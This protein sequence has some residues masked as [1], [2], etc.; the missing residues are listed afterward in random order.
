MTFIKSILQFVLTLLSLIIGY[1]YF[2][3]QL[4]L[5]LIFSALVFMMFSYINYQLK[6]KFPWLYLLLSIALFSY[7][8]IFVDK[9]AIL[10]YA[11]LSVG[12]L[13]ILIIHANWKSSQIFLGKQYSLNELKHESKKRI[14]RIKKM[15]MNETKLIEYV[16]EFN[17]FTREKLEKEDYITKPIKMG[18]GVLKNK[19]RSKK[20]NELLQKAKD[21]LYALLYGDKDINVKLDRVEFELLTI[22]IPRLKAYTLESIMK[23]A[24]I[25]SSKGTWIDPMSRTKTNDVSTDN[26]IIEVQYRE[27]HSEMIGNGIKSVLLLIN[28]LEV[29][30]VVLYFRMIKIEQS[31]LI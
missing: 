5:V 30:E 29:N 3:N 13:F 15:D 11:I 31:N 10:Q 17:S 20:G 4:E 7:F 26:V 9:N 19:N 2:K 27:V 14:K 21:V 22:T 1:L 23:A 6:R 25:T 24:S 8:Y 18:K 28:N 12:T 16:Q